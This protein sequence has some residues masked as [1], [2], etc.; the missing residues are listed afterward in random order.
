MYFILKD[1]MNFIPERCKGDRANERG[2]AG[3]KRVFH[4]KA[5]LIVLDEDPLHRVGYF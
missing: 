2:T 5:R 3:H 1:G 4:L